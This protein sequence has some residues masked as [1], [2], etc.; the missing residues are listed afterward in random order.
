VEESF[1]LTVV[2]CILLF[3][4]GALLVVYI[5]DCFLMPF[6]FGRILVDIRTRYALRRCQERLGKVHP[7]GGVDWGVLVFV[8]NSIVRPQMEIMCRDH[9]LAVM[10]IM[11]TYYAGDLESLTLVELLGELLSERRSALSSLSEIVRSRGAILGRMR[12]KGKSAPGWVKSEFAKRE[13][14]LRNSLNSNAQEINKI[15]AKLRDRISES[16]SQDVIQ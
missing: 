3:T 5:L 15:T 13:E 14:E 11:L 6:S 4:I 8:Q 1:S 10:E 2:I 9:N 7:G 12:S 16:R